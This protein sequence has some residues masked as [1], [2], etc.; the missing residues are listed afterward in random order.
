VTRLTPPGDVRS[1][2]PADAD[3]VI[4][5]VS[6]EKAVMSQPSQLPV[7]SETQLW[8]SWVL[9]LVT[10][11]ALVGAVVVALVLALA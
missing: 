9:A 8:V 2:R 3:V 5:T 4:S 6:S 1:P 11:V 7:P 10:L